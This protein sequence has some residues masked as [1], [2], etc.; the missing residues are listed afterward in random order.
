MWSKLCNRNKKIICET[1][2]EKKPIK[3]KYFIKVKLPEIHIFDINDTLC[4]L[5]YIIKRK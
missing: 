5:Y 4:E 3:E 2:I 1:Q